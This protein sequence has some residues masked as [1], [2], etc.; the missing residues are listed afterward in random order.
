MDGAAKGPFTF[1][2]GQLTKEE[3]EILLKGCLINYNRKKEGN[4]K[5]E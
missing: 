1:R 3:R 5:D 4:G 2:I